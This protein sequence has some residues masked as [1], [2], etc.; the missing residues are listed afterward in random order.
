MKIIKGAPE[1]VEKALAA[2]LVARA[3]WQTVN[4]TNQESKN[5]I[6]SKNIFR[7]EMNGKRITS[8]MRDFLMS[9]SDFEKYCVLVYKRNLEKGID[10]G[11]PDL[12]FWTVQKA[13]YDAE[14]AYIDAVA[15]DIPEY[16]PKVIN[17]VKKNV[18]WR[19]KFFEIAGL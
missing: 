11:G 4:E 9:A 19:K 1:H 2:V 8:Y 3:K 18:K 6:L 13:V 10:S 15:A 17:D 7:E 14:D 16:T 12:T 5:E